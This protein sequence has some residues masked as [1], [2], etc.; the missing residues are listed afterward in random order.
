MKQ[1]GT[2]TAHSRS[3]PLYEHETS[4][5]L[6]LEMLPADR[7][8]KELLDVEALTLDFPWGN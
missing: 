7:V 8:E 1:N 3:W 2:I 5:E 6:V 4:P